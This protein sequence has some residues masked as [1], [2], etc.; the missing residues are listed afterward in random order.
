M[1]GWMSAGV[2]A[3]TDPEAFHPDKSGTVEPAKAVC[4]VCPVR[5]RCLSYALETNQRFGVWGGTSAQ[6]RQALRLA[7]RRAA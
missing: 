4:A 1:T 6:Q 2:C 3:Q 7:E 5:E